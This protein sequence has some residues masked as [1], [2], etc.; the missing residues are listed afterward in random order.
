MRPMHARPGRGLVLLALLLA[1]GCLAPRPAGTVTAAKPAAGPQG[2]DAVMLV[3]AVIEQP[4]GDGYL[5]RDLWAALDEGVVDLERKAVLE[6]NGFRVAVT[7]GQP[8]DGLLDLLLSERSNPAARQLSTRAGTAKAINLGEPRAACA[9]EVQ[10][11]GAAAAVELAQAQCQ[12]AVTP[13]PAGDGRVRLT[14]VPQVQHGEPQ[15]LAPSGDGEWRLHGDRPVKAFPGL[16]FEVTLAPQD[17]VVIGTQAARDQTLGH[18]CFVTADGAKPV[19]RL[20]AI[21]AGRLHAPADIPAGDGAAA[22]LASQAA[23]A[24]VRGAGE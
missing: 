20:L 23:A 8:P 14:I 22:P 2:A 13:A 21:R 18:R 4:V 7:G 9:F 6:D 17:Y 12:L 10:E 3:V 16:T 5:N 11:N 19:Q 1:G 24:T 15:L